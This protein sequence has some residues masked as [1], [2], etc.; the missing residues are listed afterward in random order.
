MLNIQKTYAQ[1]IEEQK[2]LTDKEKAALLAHV[3]LTRLGGKVQKLPHADIDVYA[4]NPH[5][6]REPLTLVTFAKVNKEGYQP[7]LKVS[8]SA[9][10][11]DSILAGTPSEMMQ[12]LWRTELI[13]IRDREHQRMKTALSEQ[14][15]IHEN[16]IASA[17]DNE[18]RDAERTK[19]PHQ[20]AQ[21]SVKQAQ[22]SRGLFKR[23]FS[24]ATGNTAA[25]GARVSK[26]EEG[27]AGIDEKIQ[28][29][30][31]GGEIKLSADVR[32]Y[33]A[34]K[35]ELDAYIIAQHEDF[36][37]ESEFD[38]MEQAF[39]IVMAKARPASPPSD[40]DA[41]DPDAPEQT[42]AMSLSLPGENIADERWDHVL[43]L[44]TVPEE[45]PEP[46]SYEGRRRAY[47][48]ALGR[49]REASSYGFDDEDEEREIDRGPSHT[50]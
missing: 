23:S 33:E 9:A 49:G 40:P 3:F 37:I 26:A 38:S 43:E 24:W 19:I 4:D 29:I 1:A 41:D 25:E 44:A 22:D 39:K 46:D 12:T 16:A 27:L 31:R 6:A 17:I 11:I 21:R 48:Q 2:R 30:R 10:E 36:W 42:M 50:Y 15:S 45:E 35:A 32:D 8:E 14:K 13:S 18:V 5:G 7:V 34:E 47:M 20:D 28:Q